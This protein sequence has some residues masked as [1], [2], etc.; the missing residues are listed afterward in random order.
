[1]QYCYESRLGRFILSREGCTWRIEFN[2]VPI[3]DGYASAEQALSCLV[4]GDGLTAAVAELVGVADLP[5][6]LT[7][8]QHVPPPADPCSP[9]SARR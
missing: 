3:G 5:S 2:D 8:W 6:S 4:R 7:A 9:S 1:M